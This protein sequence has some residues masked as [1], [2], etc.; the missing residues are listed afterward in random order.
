MAVKPLKQS[1]LR[2]SSKPI[3]S[4]PFSQE[5]FMNVFS[6]IFV[7]ILLLN[8]TDIWAFNP[9]PANPTSQPNSYNPSVYSDG[10]KR[11]GFE[12]GT[13]IEL[14]TVEIQ[15]APSRESQAIGATVGGVLGAAIGSRSNS[16]S[17][18]AASAALGAIGGLLGKTIADTASARTYLAHEIVIDLGDN[19]GVV[20]VQEQSDLALGDTV[21]IIRGSQ[22][23]RVVRV[24]AR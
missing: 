13:V 19:R 8:S 9:F 6:S 4:A 17:R 3:Q 15:T 2:F 22:G 12:V 10:F 11:Q 1:L 24:A 23:D 16:S 18:F 20:I 7:A 14:R 21:R 5:I